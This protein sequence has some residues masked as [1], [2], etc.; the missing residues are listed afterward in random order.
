MERQRE[1]GTQSWT[2]E[3]LPTALNCALWVSGGRRRACSQT[4]AHAVQ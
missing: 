3:V 4:G 2:P 1:E